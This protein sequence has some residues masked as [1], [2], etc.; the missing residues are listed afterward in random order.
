VRKAPLLAAPALAALLLAACGSSGDSGKS[1]KRGYIN[2]VD[3]ICAQ[4]ISDM[5]ETNSRLDELARSARQVSEFQDD[6]A[7]GQFEARDELDSIKKVPVPKGSE[8]AMEKIETA[9]DHQLDLIDQLIVASRHN[10]AAAFKQLSDEVDSARQTVQG[11]TDEFGFKIC[12][13][14]T[15]DS[16]SR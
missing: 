16:T 14:D 9:R 8:A 12:G 7:D 6:L 11:L 3:A 5:R 13:Q 15:A 10:D 4:T 2:T 1:A